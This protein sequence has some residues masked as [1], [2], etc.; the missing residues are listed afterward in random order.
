M[1]SALK[2]EGLFCVLISEPNVTIFV[3]DSNDDP[4]YIRS[5][6]PA[7]VEGKCSRK[8]CG[9]CGAP[10]NWLAMPRTAAPAAR[11]A[12]RTEVFRNPPSES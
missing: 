5:W 4:S 10:S 12:L 9:S 7:A 8:N 2:I 1:A 11:L 6:R 3:F